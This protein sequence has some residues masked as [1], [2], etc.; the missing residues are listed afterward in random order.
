MVKRA[1]ATSRFKGKSGSSL[2]I[3][4]PAGLKVDRL[5]VAGTGKAGELK[6]ED[7]IKIGGATIGGCDASADAV[8]IVAELPGGAMKPD[9][10]ASIASGV[11]LRAYS[12]D[13]YKTKKKDDEAR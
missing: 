11:R 5:I 2:D 9:Q 10:T 3:L 1:A 8:T 4:A 6:A 12:F 13:R 7:Y